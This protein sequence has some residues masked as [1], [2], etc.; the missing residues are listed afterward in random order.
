MADKRLA[1]DTLFIVAEPDFIFYAADEKAKHKWLEEEFCESL[2]LQH[3]HELT[4]EIHDPELRERFIDEHIAYDQ[5]DMCQGLAQWNL[6]MW[7]E[8]TEHRG[9]YD[10]NGDWIAYDWGESGTD[11]ENNPWVV[12]VFAKPQ[13]P[14]RWEF[15]DEHVSP[16]LRDLVGYM[17]AAARVGRGGLVWAGWNAIQ[18][19][20]PDGTT[21]KPKRTGSP[22]SGAQL[23]MCTSDAMRFLLPKWQAMP[24]KHMGF[25][26]AQLA[27]ECQDLVGMA[28]LLPPIGGFF[29]HPSTTDEGL[30]QLSSHFERAWSQEGTRKR[31]EEQRDRYLCAFTQKGPPK[32]LHDHPIAFPRD[33]EV[34]RW[35]TQKP[36]GTNDGFTGWHGWHC[37][38]EVLLLK[39]YLFGRHRWT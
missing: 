18:W 10:R 37:G 7:P 8:E 11:T 13:K 2:Q 34:L 26:L 31:T 22:C 17:T 1:G 30:V 33:R 20:K 38:K 21:G 25:V 3:M 29:T 16:E 4:E 5:R 19:T 23:I 39:R 27:E 14:E 28:Y 24:N 35:K 12:K 9:N 15:A 6:D 36:P 32:R